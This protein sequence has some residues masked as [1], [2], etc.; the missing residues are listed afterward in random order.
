[1]ENEPEYGT[2]EKMAEGGND[3][4]L[5]KGKANDYFKGELSHLSG[6]W[7][8]PVEPGRLTD[9]SWRQ[10]RRVWALNTLRVKPVTNI[11]LS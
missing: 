5:L 11:E 6:L 9:E 1:M 10:T 3:A 7:L 8:S 4:E 2:A